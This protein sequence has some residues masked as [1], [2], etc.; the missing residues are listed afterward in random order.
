MCR[1]LFAIQHAD[2]VCTVPLVLK[3]NGSAAA[4]MSAIIESL[5]VTTAMAVV[6]STLSMEGVVVALAA[7]NS[8]SS[9][10]KHNFF[11]V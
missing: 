4:A 2:G 10:C 11:F 8:K 3:Y 9:N 1:Q 5:L 6:E 7:L